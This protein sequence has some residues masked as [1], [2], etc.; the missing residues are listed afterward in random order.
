[1]VAPNSDYA[2]LRRRLL[3]AFPERAR[4]QA[5]QN[6]LIVMVSVGEV[7]VDFLLALPGY[8]EQIVERALLRDLGGFSAWVCS[9]E[10]LIIQK[11]IAGREKDW[12]DVDSLLRAQR[13]KL[14]YAYIDEWLGQFAE[15]LEQPELLQRFRQVRE[16]I[17]TSRQT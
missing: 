3:A 8:D 16:R 11:V 6:P 13:G 14:D 2:A 17:G 9:A 12:L 15:A 1:V 4:Q 5:P 10:D 7:I